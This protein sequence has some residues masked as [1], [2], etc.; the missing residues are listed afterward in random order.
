[1]GRHIPDDLSVVGYDNIPMASV[2][3]PP[4]TTVD[5]LAPDMGQTAASM[6]FEILRGGQPD[7]IEMPTQLIIRHSSVAI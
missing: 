5:Q 3:A 7:S 2:F 6:L 4:L 1:M